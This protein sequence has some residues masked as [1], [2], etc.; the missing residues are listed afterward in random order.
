MLFCLGLKA[1]GEQEQGS[2]GVPKAL[3]LCK[4][5]FQDTRV[6][7]CAGGARLERDQPCITYG[8]RGLICL[9]VSVQ[10]PDGDLH[11]GQDGGLFNEPLSDLVKILSSLSNTD[12]T[13]RVPGFYD[14]VTLPDEREKQ[15]LACMSCCLDTY[16]KSSGLHHI[17]PKSSAELLRRRWL[18]PSCT[19]NTVETSENGWS[20]IPKLASAKVSLRIVPHQDANKVIDAFTKHL[21]EEFAKLQSPGNSVAVTVVHNKE[22]WISDPC[23]KFYACMA[24]SVEKVWGCR[25]QFIR[26]G[27]TTP[28]IPYLQRTLS[29]TAIHIPICQEND[30]A[31]RGNESLAREDIIRG[32]EVIKHFLMSWHDSKMGC[33]A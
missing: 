31:H 12:G 13:I 10:G 20:V 29:A 16:K 33:C 7:L 11:S 6:I 19:I 1:D 5:W 3:H 22:W 15:Q 18:Q 17:R 14:N 28:V 30:N 24:N 23:D 32:K 27:R 2:Q 4:D 26:D 21:E 25:P 8:M 9:E